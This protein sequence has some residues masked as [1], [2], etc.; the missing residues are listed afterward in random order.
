MTDENQHFL[1]IP[2]VFSARFAWNIKKRDAFRLHCFFDDST[3]QFD[4]WICV[5]DGIERL[6]H[7]FDHLRIRTTRKQC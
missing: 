7:T 4:I 3:S 5:I 6:D 2:L 1:K